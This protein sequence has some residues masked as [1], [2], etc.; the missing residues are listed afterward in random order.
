MDSQIIECRQDES[1]NTWFIKI[2]IDDEGKFE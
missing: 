2:D 1:D